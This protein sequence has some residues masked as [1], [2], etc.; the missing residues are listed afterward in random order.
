MVSAQDSDDMCAAR[1]LPPGT[2]YLRQIIRTM[3]LPADRKD[4]F[5]LSEPAVAPSGDETNFLGASAW[6]RLHL[7]TIPSRSLVRWRRQVL[8]RRY[9]VPLSTL[10]PRSEDRRVGKECVSTCRSR[11]SPYH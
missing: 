11:W 10:Q 5:G 9:E 7:G 2:G 6:A 4:D 8:H 3:A 1:K